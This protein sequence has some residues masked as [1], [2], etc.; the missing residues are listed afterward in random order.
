LL[1][2]RPCLE[3]RKSITIL[4]DRTPIEKFLWYHSWQRNK[5]LRFL[6]NLMEWATPK[7][8]WRKTNMRSD[9]I[10]FISLCLQFLRDIQTILLKFSCGF[11]TCRNPRYMTFLIPVFFLFLTFWV[12]V[13]EMGLSDF[14]AQPCRKELPKRST[15]VFRMNTMCRQ[16]FL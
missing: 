16:F 1:F 13:V 14:R 4:E 6:W 12:H 9:L 5:N 10:V 3:Q 11:C 7:E 15:I 8:F 2:D